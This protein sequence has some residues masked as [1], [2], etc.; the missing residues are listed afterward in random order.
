MD[1]DGVVD[2]V[3]LS[4]MLRFFTLSVNSA[5]H[6][7]ALFVTSSPSH[8]SHGQIRYEYY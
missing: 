3:C 4:V 2:Y 8:F 5:V 7:Q 6:Y 1:W